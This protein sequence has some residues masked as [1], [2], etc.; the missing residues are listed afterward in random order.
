MSSIMWRRRF[1]IGS[2]IG[3]NSCRGIATRNPDRQLVADETPLSP[4][5]GKVR[6]CDVSE[7]ALLSHILAI[8]VY[9]DSTSL[10]SVDEPGDDA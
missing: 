10:S 5:V 4:N 6:M 9:E 3:G 8:T 2:G 7:M 1:E